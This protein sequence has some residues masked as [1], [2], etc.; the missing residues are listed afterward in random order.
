MTNREIVLEAVA[1]KKTDI[2][3]Y[4]ININFEVWEKL[5]AYYGGRENFPQHET[6]LAGM[7]CNWR[8]ESLPGNQFRDIFGVVW[9]QGNIFHI[10]E[11]VLKEPSLKGFEFP[12]LIKDEDVP[13]LVD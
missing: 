2:I 3:P 7:G 11:P 9:Q 4:A 5:D 1:H 8:A 6:F 13:A 12:T 10:V